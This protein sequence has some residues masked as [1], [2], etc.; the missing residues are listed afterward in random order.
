MYKGSFLLHFSRDLADA[1]VRRLQQ[2]LVQV[3]THFERSSQLMRSAESHVGLVRITSQ[4]LSNLKA[5]EISCRALKDLHPDLLKGPQRQRQRCEELNRE[6]WS[7]AGPGR[8]Q[9]D[10]ESRFSCHKRARIEKRCQEKD[11]TEKRCQERAGV[12]QR[13][14][15]RAGSV[16][17]ELALTR[18]TYIGKQRKTQNPSRPSMKNNTLQQG[19][20]HETRAKL[21]ENHEHLK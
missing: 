10:I 20:T 4:E 12:E 13:C 6:S 15:E 16:M 7:A 14:Q 21:R 9:A 5:V 3:L 18:W 17:R 19:I 2:D 1:R 11:G 8:C